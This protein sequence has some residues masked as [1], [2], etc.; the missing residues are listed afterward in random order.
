[1]RKKPCLRLL[2]P[3]IFLVFDHSGSP[4]I[5][6]YGRSFPPYPAKMIPQ[7]AAS[8]AGGTS[9]GL[10]SRRERQHV[11][12]S[13][14]HAS[15]LHISANNGSRH[16]PALAR[17]RPA[18]S[19]ATQ[20]PSAAAAAICCRSTLS[21]SSCA[22]A[23]DSAPRSPLRTVSTPPSRPRLMS[24]RAE[25]DLRILPLADPLDESRPVTSASPP[26]PLP[27]LLLLPF[28][29]LLLLVATPSEGMARPLSPSPSSLTKD[30]S[31]SS[32]GDVAPT[33]RC[34]PR[35]EA[36]DRR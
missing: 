23:E 29:L 33:V 7:A 5:T 25:T 30:G 24:V 35:G 19:N 18:R 31:P 20:R 13:N 14:G 27:M 9:G 2:V 15:S 11:A 21:G 4:R 12:A 6:R 10:H 34:R 1:M 3:L 32:S 8:G 16:V 36:R 28:M 17:V 22:A 26:L